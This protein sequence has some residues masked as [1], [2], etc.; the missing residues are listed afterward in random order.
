MDLTVS[1]NE[2]SLWLSG[3]LGDD[4][5]ENIVYVSFMR[6]SDGDYEIYY[7][8]NYNDDETTEYIEKIETEIWANT[9]SQFELYRAFSKVV[10]L[11]HEFHGKGVYRRPPQGVCL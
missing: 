11:P 4:V 10:L 6:I 1:E 9:Q 8:V 2:F 5:P 7:Y 3:A